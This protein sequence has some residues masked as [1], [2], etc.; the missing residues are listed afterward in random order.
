MDDGPAADQQPLAIT[1]KSSPSRRSCHRPR[2]LRLNSDIRL[3]MNEPS[4]NK[5]F[6]ES[7]INMKSGVADA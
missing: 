5:S 6:M 3:V 2:V 1:G 4:M 7:F